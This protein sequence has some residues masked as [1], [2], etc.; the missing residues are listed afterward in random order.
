MDTNYD[1]IDFLPSGWHELARK[2]IQE[3]KIVFPDFKI[4]ELKEKFGA[5]RCYHN[6]PQE[7]D[8]ITD[9][10]ENLT[11]KTCCKCGA[12]ATKYSTSWILPWCD[13]CGQDDEKFYTKERFVR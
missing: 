1:W 7:V 5:L 10:Y 11:S 9:R 3:C 12:P 8:D 4:Y 6:G 2:M 13:K